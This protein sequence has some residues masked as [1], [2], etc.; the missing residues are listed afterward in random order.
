MERVRLPLG[1]LAWGLMGLWQLGL[2]L[3]MGEQSRAGSRLCAVAPATP[4]PT[5]KVCTT[6]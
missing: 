3:H 6:N 2:H 1:T 4:N 5:Y